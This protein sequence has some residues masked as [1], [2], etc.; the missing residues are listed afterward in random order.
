MIILQILL[1]YFITSLVGAGI[2]FWLLGKYYP[3]WICYFVWSP[4]IGLIWLTLSGTLLVFCN[5][6][7][8]SWCSWWLLL[9]LL[10]SISIGYAS[11]HS[12]YAGIKEKTF[13]YCLGGGILSLLLLALPV[14]V[15]GQ[16]F[17]ILRGNGTDAFNYVAMANTLN[18]MPYDFFMQSSPEWLASKEPFY[19]LAQTLINGTRWPVSMLL[20]LFSQWLDLPPYQFEY[21]FSLY[22]FLLEYLVTFLFALKLSLKPHVCLLLSLA[23]CL[24]FWGQWLLDIRAQSQISVMPLMMASLFFLINLDKKNKEQY[25]KE[26]LLF[27]FLLSALVFLYVEIV[28]LIACAGFILL[29]WQGMNKYKNTQYLFLYYFF[30]ILIVCLFAFSHFSYWSNLLTN[31]LTQAVTHKNNWEQAY[32]EWLYLY[33][34]AGI[35]GLSVF[36]E[37]F[38][39]YA[40]C[41]GV[42]LTF[43]SLIALKLTYQ[44]KGEKTI[45]GANI[46]LAIILAGGTAFLYLYFHQQF[47]TAGKAL[48][49]IY[50]FIIILPV[51]AAFSASENQSSFRKF[52]FNIQ[53]IVFFWLGLQIFLGIWHIYNASEGKEYEHYMWFHGEHNQHIWASDAIEKAIFVNCTTLSLNLS[54]EWLKEYWSFVLSQKIPI[55]KT[56]SQYSSCELID[57][58]SPLFKPTQHYL[59]E[60]GEVFLIQK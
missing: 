9:S 14:I 23:V 25:W 48:G 17:S 7:V 45:S 6:P 13:P 34:Y 44:K 20:A 1:L 39:I 12:I 5:Y 30:A 42:V 8:S 54:S 10:V 27:C 37:Q 60:N 32:F 24:G 11:H 3:R 49:Y 55:T 31:M 35:W 52:W 51:W 19:P 15:G 47:W 41:I 2:S 21:S 36:S 18:Y 56:D 59:A 16:S 40:T 43:L 29:V 38:N 46:M 53:V 57:K 28:P 50:P 26:C 33:P 22:F 4:I 58:A